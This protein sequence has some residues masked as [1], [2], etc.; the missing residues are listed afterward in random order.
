MTR[1]MKTRMMKNTAHRLS[2]YRLQAGESFLF[3]TNVWLYLLHPAPSGS[4]RLSDI[5]SRAIK[6]MLS[7]DV[8]LVVDV[9]VVSEYLNTFCRIEWSAY[10]RRRYPDFKS[11]RSSSDFIGVGE[12]AGS[13]VRRILEMSKPVDHHFTRTDFEYV[14]TDFETGRKDFNDGLLADACRRNGWKLVTHDAD[15][16]TGGIEV[17]T[18]N[19]KLLRACP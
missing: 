2:H 1:T 10:H 8:H 18:M 11:F 3:D 4:T 14:L 19:R 17:L 16:T 15:F 12:R 9:L 6:P 13:N 5:Y 7:R